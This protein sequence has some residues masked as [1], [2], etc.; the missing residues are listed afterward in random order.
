MK[1]MLILTNIILV[2][3][4]GALHF[5]Y[6]RDFQSVNKIHLKNSL[7]NV[8]DVPLSLAASYEKQIRQSKEVER[9]SMKEDFLS[10]IESIRYG[11]N[12]FIFIIDGSGRM[13]NH[14]LR[15]GLSWWNM[16]FETDAEGN[17]IFRDM[18]ANA[19]R[20]GEI[21]L[22]T[23]WQSKY[24][25]EIIENQIIYGKYFWPWDWIICTVSYES[26]TVQVRPM[27]TTGILAVAIAL[28]IL[29]NLVI[30]FVFRFGRW[31]VK[32]KL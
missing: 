17:Y 13:V 25:E 24:H 8:I 9:E 31:G 15:P 20:D 7:S 14:P 16:L 4:I 23:Q 29:D 3:A 28:L 27:H 19:K 2:L 26:E 12:N 32:K 18:I 10:H 5:L 21:L 30:L 22:E 6:I 1:R 11:K